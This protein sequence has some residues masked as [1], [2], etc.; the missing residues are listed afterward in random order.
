VIRFA[1]FGDILLYVMTVN[2]AE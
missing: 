1:I 2:V